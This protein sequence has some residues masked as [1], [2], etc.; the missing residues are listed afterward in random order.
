MKNMYLYLTFHKDSKI[1]YKSWNYM[2]IQ[3]LEDIT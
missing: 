3:I 1:Y 2:R